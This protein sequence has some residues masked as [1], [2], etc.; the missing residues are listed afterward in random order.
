MCIIPVNVCF[1]LSLTFV[2]S[3]WK[4]VLSVKGACGDKSKFSFGS[5]NVCIINREPTFEALQRL[6]PA[7]TEITCPRDI[8]SADGVYSNGS[9]SEHGEQPVRRRLTR[10]T[11]TKMSP[12][13]RFFMPKPSRKKNHAVVLVVTDSTP[14]DCTLIKPNSG[15]TEVSIYEAIT[16]HFLSREPHL[17]GGRDRSID[18]GDP[19]CNR[20]CCYYRSV[21]TMSSE[22]MTE[23]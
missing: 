23:N 20:G 4:F 11:A 12:G 14:L 10:S 19:I 9:C 17:A 3:G 8:H 18:D 2:V 21:A 22:V 16:S 13:Y 15:R 7:V 6:F 1:I 5:P